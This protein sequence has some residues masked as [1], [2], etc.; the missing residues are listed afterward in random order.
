MV[1]RAMS[2]PYTALKF[3]F[4]EDKENSIKN[5]LGF[6]G[7]GG[8]TVQDAQGSFTSTSAADLNGS[9]LAIY[10]H[11]NLATKSVMVTRGIRPYA[12]CQT[13]RAARHRSNSRRP[14][15]AD[16]P[17][18]DRYTLSEAAAPSQ[19]AERRVLL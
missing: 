12:P 4:E 2:A 3:H 17:L 14:G 1:V 7:F 9:V 18:S 10:V 6:V 13:L 8:A 19:M 15:P 16:I 5:E 11:T